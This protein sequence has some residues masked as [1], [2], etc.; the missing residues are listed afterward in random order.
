LRPYAVLLYVIIGISVFALLA[1]LVGGFLLARN[2]A[3]PLRALA[4]A[5]Q[6]IK[7]GFAGAP[8]PV[9]RDDELGRLIEAFNLA[10]SMAAEMSDLKAQDQLRRE[11]VAS[12]SHDLRTP[13][14]SLHGYLETMQMQAGQVPDAE[15]ERYL[16]IAVRQSEKVG[17][18][19]QELFELAKLECQA[20]PLQIETFNLPELIQDVTQKYGMA[21]KQRGITLRA[22]L[23]KQIP[24]VCA[25]IALIERVLTNLIDNALKHTPAGGLVQIE[26]FD[27]AGRIRIEVRDSGVGIAPEF[28]PKLFERESP[29]SRQ[30]RAS[31]GGLGLLIVARIV[32]LH[33]GRM[34][35]ESQVGQGTLFSFDLS[36]AS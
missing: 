36:V 2:I 30:V 20:I 8:L 1:I 7:E 28:L 23:D 21:A 11:L 14:T 3:Q 34:N 27:M 32:S 10:S 6:R 31:G 26:L 33:G 17:R 16:A 12:V 4:G 19:A 5:T 25:D 24:L 35:V 9:T 29:L 18:L 22:K 15:R 13:L